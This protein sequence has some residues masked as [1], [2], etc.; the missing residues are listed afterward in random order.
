MDLKKLPIRE[1]LEYFLSS[2]D[3]DNPRDS[4]AWQEFERRMRPV[5]AAA[6]FRTLS[7]K[8]QRGSELR[9]EFIQDTFVLLLD[10]DCRRLRNMKWP[11]QGAIF[12]FMQVIACHTVIDHYRKNG[13][14][15]FVDL[16]E[17]AILGQLFQENHFGS[18]AEVSDLRDRIDKYLLSRASKSHYERDRN[19]FWFFYRWGYTDKEIAALPAINLSRKKVENT[20]RQLLLEVKRELKCGSDPEVE[21]Q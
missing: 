18:T 7:S 3:S 21:E 16:D 17:P 13:R 11:H 9:D 12:R 5:I 2:G 15:S 10:E 20:R 19:I 1:L 4:D 6:I 14:F 8:D